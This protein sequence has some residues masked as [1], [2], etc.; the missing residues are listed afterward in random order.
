MLPLRPATLGEILDRTANLYRACFLVFAGIAAIPALVVVLF[1]TGTV[2][3]SWSARNSGQDPAAMAGLGLGVFALMLLF[4]PAWL[5]VTALSN[6]AMTWAADQEYLGERATIRAAYK[7]AWQRGWGAVGLFTIQALILWAV[8]GIV[9]AFSIAGVAALAVATHGANADPSWALILVIGGGIMA[10]AMFMLSRLCLAFPVFMTENASVGEALRRGWRLSAG[11][12]WRILVVYLLRT[13]LGWVA[14][15]AMAVPLLLLMA[16]LPH[17]ASVQ[18]QQTYT[19]MA[20]LT[21][22]GTS[23]LGQMLAKPV[24]GIALVV[25]CYDQKIRHEAFDIEWMMRQAGMVEAPAPSAQAWTAA[26][27]AGI[28]EAKKP[29]SLQSPAPPAGESA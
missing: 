2:L 20:M 10:Y 4:L 5:G 25:F 23:F 18:H 24:S 11:T 29:A 9:M 12:R 26:T 1:Y 17:S 15:I 3:L 14:W 22:Y 13:M 19:V 8:S 28:V 7:A 27:S 21:V 16:Y 6:A